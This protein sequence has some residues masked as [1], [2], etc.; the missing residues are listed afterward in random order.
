[1]STVVKSVQC[2]QVFLCLL[3]HRLAF[4]ALWFRT[5]V[6]YEFLLQGCK[7]GFLDAEAEKLM[8]FVRFTEVEH[9]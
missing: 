8:S 6:L 4:M 9:T 5:D 7:N 2:C 1:M 3:E